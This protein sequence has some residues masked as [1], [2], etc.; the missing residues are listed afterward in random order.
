MLIVFSY[1]VLPG[2]VTADP[3]KLSWSILFSFSVYNYSTLLGGPLG[4]E[5]GWRGY[6]LPRLETRYGPLLSSVILGALWAGWHLPLFFIPGWTS[7]PW[8][9]YVLILIG[10]SVILTFAVNMAC[11]AVV[12]AIVMHA[13]FNTVSTFLNGLFVNVQPSGSMRFELV[14][15]LCGLSVALILVA[16]TRGRLGYG[17]DEGS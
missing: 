12:P 5:P 11:F 15:A 17:S 2:L 1:V 16:I 13:L 8:W 10:Q 7:A 14:L 4:E 3:R 9:I 6:A